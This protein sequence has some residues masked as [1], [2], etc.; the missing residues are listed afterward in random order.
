MASKRRARGKAARLTARTADKYALYLE[1]VQDP[2]AEASRLA[3]V[4]RRL[5]GRGAR[6][7]REDFCG[8]AAI[9][10]AWARQG[11]DHRAVGVDLDPGPLA[12]GTAHNLAS[13]SGTARARVRLV[14]ADVMAT[15][16]LALGRFDLICGYNFSYWVL[17][18]RAEMLG[19]MRACR[20]ALAPGGL[21]ALDFIGGSE[22]LTEM[23]ERTRCRGFDYVW[24][25]D[26]YD[27]VSGDWRAHI[28]FEFR[29][30]TR[31][32][33]AFT[34]HWRLWTLPELRDLLLE[35]GFSR[36][37]TLLEGDDPKGGGNG[38]FRERNWSEAHRCFLAYLIAER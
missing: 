11:R 28:D 31:L 16:T 8:T 6:T 19:Y 2:E 1:A 25:Q 13:L 9:C 10:C 5:R 18:T 3:R 20:R 27:P 7:L 36:V 29:D 33:R 32:R 38:V 22:V 14:R 12:W 21:L 23:R 26:R 30:G 4:Y 34:Y 35:A 24:D 17:R 15:R 37:R